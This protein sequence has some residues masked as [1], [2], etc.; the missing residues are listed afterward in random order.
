MHSV[1]LQPIITCGNF[2]SK[3]NSKT[4]TSHNDHG[5][6]FGDHRI[7]VESYYDE[8][9]PFLFAWIPDIFKLNHPNIMEALKINQFRLITPYDV[10]LTIRN[11]NQI[12]IGSKKGSEGCPK[13]QSLFDVVNPNRTCQD[14][15]VHDKWC[16]CHE[17]YPLHKD[18]ERTK[19][20]QF[21]V[22][23]IKS[24]IATVKTKNCYTC[25]SLS[26][27][28]VNRIH[29]YYDK[30]RINIYYV[31]AITL[32][33]GN[34]SYEAIVMKDK[35]RFHLIGQISVISPYKNF[36][37]CTI[38]DKDRLFCVCEKIVNCEL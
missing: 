8:R 35:S 2:F 13:C 22:N 15:A 11:V 27:G 33:P 5:I 32:T 31:V 18:N 20:V 36:G 38:Q 9:M 19:T 24:I 29:Y 26:L 34:M 14:V 3:V 37:K 28:K 7:Y 4:V 16:S 21:V 1:Y 30:E 6:R 10:Y 12:P 17:L 23:H 25:T